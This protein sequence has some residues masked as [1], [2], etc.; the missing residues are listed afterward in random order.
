M[1]EAGRSNFI[2]H[3]CT[4][5]ALGEEGQRYTYLRAY[6]YLSEEGAESMEK[7]LLEMRI[8]SVG[9][10]GELIWIQGGKSGI[11]GGTLLDFSTQ[12]QDSLRVSRVLLNDDCKKR[13]L[14]LRYWLP[15]ATDALATWYQKRAGYRVLEC[16]GLQSS[17]DAKVFILNQY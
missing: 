13:N 7:P 6:E 10:L 15:L 17:L 2:S 11:A 9:S 16:E 12:I 8:N 14:S 4:Q 3:T 5:E 1:L